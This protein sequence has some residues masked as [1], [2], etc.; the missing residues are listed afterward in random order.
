MD[1]LLVNLF[2][3]VAQ[4]FCGKNYK[5]LNQNQKNNIRKIWTNKKEFDKYFNSAQELFENLKPFGHDG[6]IT[7]TIVKTVVDVFGEYNI[8]SHP[9]QIDREGCIRGKRK[10]IE[11]FLTCPPKEVYFAKNK[12]EY[13]L[14]GG[15]RNIL[16][17]DWKPYLLNWKNRG[18]IAIQMRSDTFVSK[19]DAQEFLKKEFQKLN[20]DNTVKI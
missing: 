20:I 18:G 4:R 12:A 8:L 1:G 17:D 19:D 16:V 13:A 9:T 15:T 2:D 11:K 6:E 10:W 7:N 3:T 5:E 14:D